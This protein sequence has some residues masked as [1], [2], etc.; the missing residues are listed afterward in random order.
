MAIVAV[1]PQISVE[2]AVFAAH[3]RDWVEGGVQIIG[4]CCGTT[5]E[6]IRAMI[7]ALPDAIGPRRL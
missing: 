4:G 5:I 3:C 6:H 1:K 2:P 7:E